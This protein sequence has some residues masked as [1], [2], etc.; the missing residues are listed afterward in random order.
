LN[1]VVAIAAGYSHDLAL[2][3]DGNVVAWGNYYNGPV[4][5]PADVANVV[6]ISTRGDR[7]LALF[8][9]RAPAVTVQPFDRSLFRGSNTT[10]NAKA[11]GAQPV[12]YQWQMYGT[13]IPGA[14]T[15]ALTLT[16]LQFAQA[17][18]YQLSV[19]N[20]YGVG[21]S[22]IAK[23]S[24]TLPLPE[25]LDTTNVPWTSSGNATWFGQTADSHD[26]V[27]AARSGSIGNGQES[28]LQTTLG[29][30]AQLGFWW[31]AS[32]ELSFDFL[33]FKL[34]GITQASI[35]GEVDWQQLSYAI[36]SGNHT[37]V[38]RYFKDPNGSAGQDA[39][40][41]D[42]VVYSINP[43]VITLQPVG[44]TTNVG[45][46]VQFSASA[47]G[48][49]PLSYQWVQNQT[50]N[51][52]V[53]S[54]ILSIAA[55]TR[56]NNGSYY[57]AV[58]NGGGATISSNAVLKVLVPQ[59][60]SAPAILNNHTIIFLSGDSDGGLLTAND[61]A[62]FTAQ[63]SSNLAN[64]VTLPNALSITN[65]FLMLQDSAQTNYPSRFYRIIEN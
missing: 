47:S 50:N 19:G 21:F 40:W 32:S 9:T 36:P 31:K 43:P 49:A 57:V 63:A 10:F 5:I 6:Q 28:I 45:A 39:G 60:F 4:T 13:N 46:P 12:S 27:D 34:D 64:W 44:L 48:L 54:P 30:P 58:V 52:G 38:W 53:N 11:V 56:T 55:A 42:Q 14:T 2:L 8:G 7:D 62:G 17:G 16:N 20:R 35:S 29:G 37:L 25:A 23:L 33:E 18:P 65:G 1:S 41:V 59:R 26:G 22:R 3:A 61:L 24:V 51:V 15:E